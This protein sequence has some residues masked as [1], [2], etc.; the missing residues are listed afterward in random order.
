MLH[1]ALALS[2]LAACATPQADPLAVDI[3]AEIR[4]LP[5]EGKKQASIA[6]DGSANLPNGAYLHVYLYFDRINEGRPIAKDTAVVKAGK[7]SLD[8]P[9]FP[10][11]NLP[12]RYIAVLL[13]NPDL[14][15]MAIPG[16]K[17]T[18]VEVSTRF[19]TEADFERE[20]KAIRAQLIA[21]LRAFVALGNEVKAKMDE[22]KGKPAE[23]WKPFLAAWAEK[24][25]ELQIRADPRQVPEYN[26]LNIDLVAT[27]GMENLA[28]ILNSAAGC[29]AN[30]KN[31][32][33]LEGLTVLHQTAEYWAGEISS[34][35]LSDPRELLALIEDARKVARDA[36]GRPDAP[37]LPARRRLIEICT[38]LQKSFPEELQ[39]GVQEVNTRATAFFTALADKDAAAKSLLAELD[40]A[41][42]KLAA[43][44]RPPK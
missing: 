17:L 25:R 3:K 42:D 18:R 34:P 23:D 33:A 31:T 32:E 30:A 19:G 11:R 2:I 16:F 35:K 5:A 9:A 4:D 29:A 7:F 24:G 40:Q 44:I 27:S 8:F 14:Q 41:L 1:A 13:F 43:P 21:D 36:A 28:G 12:G 26:V 39:P 37:T 10:K 38:V 15:D 20:S 6:C 22:L